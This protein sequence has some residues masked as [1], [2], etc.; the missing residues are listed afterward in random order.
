MFT[1]TQLYCGVGYTL[2]KSDNTFKE[3]KTLQFVGKD[4]DVYNLQVNSIYTYFANGYLVHNGS[5][6]C[7]NESDCEVCYNAQSEDD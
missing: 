7:P 2:F 1:N 3:I 6:N 4:I 5:A